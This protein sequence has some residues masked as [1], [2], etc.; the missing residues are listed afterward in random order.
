MKKGQIIVGM[1]FYITIILVIS[2]LA[3]GSLNPI[4]V[5]R[6]DSLFLK[7]IIG[8]LLT[9]LVLGPLGLIYRQVLKER[10]CAKCGKSLVDFAGPFGNPLRCN[11]CGRM[12]H[13]KCFKAGDGSIFEGCKQP[14]CS[15]YRGEFG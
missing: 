6:G 9:M 14:G 12:Y 10:N 4:E 13:S 3:T 15:S 11:F 1:I 7:L 8:I 5:F 2:K